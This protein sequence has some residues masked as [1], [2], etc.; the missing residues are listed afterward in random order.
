MRKSLGK[1]S[2]L[3]LL[4]LCCLAPFTYA[5]KP[6]EVRFSVYFPPH[7]PVWKEGLLPWTELVEKESKGQFVFKNF[8]N[9]VLNTTAQGFRA[10]S[11]NIADLA[12]GYPFTQFASFN[13]AHV[14]DLPFALLNQQGGA[15][16]METLY[17]KYLKEEYEKMG[18]Y[19]AFW[20]VTGPYNI[21]TKKP[22]H[23]LADLKGLK[24]RSG[25]GYASYLLEALGAVPVTVAGPEMYTA[26]QT[27]V[28]DGLLHMDAAIY[29]YKLHEVGSNILQININR[30]GV[31]YAL[32]KRFFDALS[33]DKKRFF[34]NKLRQASQMA[35][36]SYDI[37]DVHAKRALKEA[38]VNFTYF[39]EAEMAK[40]RELMKPVWQRFIDT[41]EAKGLPARELIEEL[42]RLSEQ[43]KDLTP[44]QA[45]EMVTNNP[46]QGIINF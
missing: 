12:H 20:V 21:I 7:Y 9:A 6:T 36:V 13:L 5:A 41:N 18:V 42:N 44:E 8:T 29:S 26:F 31:P 32:N 3:V 23:T 38:G 17:P 2:V 30:L 16:A 33:P 10:T 43:W 24:I 40:V 27:G 1:L 35:S 28:I 15:L 25:G 37:D 4:M 46:I 45:M 19:L 22:I 34:Y 14:N 39:D 11:T